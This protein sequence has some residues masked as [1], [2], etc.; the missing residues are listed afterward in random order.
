VLVVSQVIVAAGI[1]GAAILG[2]GSRDSYIGGAVAATLIGLAFLSNVSTSA[3][4]LTLS[5]T[6]RIGAERLNAL[7]PPIAWIFFA[8]AIGAAIGACVFR[9]TRTSAENRKAPDVSV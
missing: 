5:E 8:A 7:A 3:H 2:R 9:A 4:L 6:E 1:V